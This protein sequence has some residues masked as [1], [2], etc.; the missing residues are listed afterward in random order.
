[1][2]LIAVLCWVALGIAGPA[3]ALPT[4]DSTG[5]VI[6]SPDP[7]PG[8]YIVTL[9]SR[10]PEVVA[11]TVAG[12]TDRHGGQ[13]LDVYTQA[14]QGYAVATTV[15]QAEELA[16]DP[17][18]ASVEQ[19]GYVS[20]SDI[21]S[22]QSPTPSWGLDRVDQRA[23][24]GDNSYSWNA[25]GAGVTAY[26]IDSGINTSLADFGGRASV[27]FDGVT[28]STGGQDCAGHG[29]HVAGT[30]GGTT[31]G[32]A[33]K[34]SL[35]SVRVL[36][37]TG[38]GSFDQVI[39]GVN[40]VTA[41]AVKPA[42]ANM[43][44]GGAQ[45]TALDTAV[46]NSIASGI[47]Y[48]IA[49]GNQ[50]TDACTSSPADVPAALT[51]GATD[52]T[53]TRASFSDYGPCVDLFAPGVNITSDWFTSPFTQTV[54][55]TSMASPHVAGIAARYLAS[56]PSA[57]V[58]DVT[59]AVLS[60]ATTGT[61]GAAGS[62]SPNLLAY[63]GFT[64]SDA[65]SALAPCA[66]SAAAVGGNHVVHL[67]WAL[68][69]AGAAATSVNIYRGT[70]PGAEGNTPF[71]A[72]LAPSTTSF[73]DT[74]AQ[75]GTTYYYQVAAVNGSGEA[76]SNEVAAL[77]AGPPGA[78]TLSVP[79]A[80]N[81]TV[82]LS[83]TAPASNGGSPITQYKI[84]RGTSPGGEGTSSIA[85]VGSA[86]TSYDDGTVTNG[87]TYYYQVAA[88]NSAGETRS[89]ERSASPIGPPAAP[90]VTPSPH[91]TSI[92]LSWPVPASGG[93][94][95]TSYRVYRGTSPGAEA[96]TPISPGNYTQTTFSDSAV[97]QGV[98]YYYQVTAVDSANRE[99]ARS[100]EIVSVAGATIDVF[101]Q[102]GVAGEI[103]TQRVTG[104]SAAPPTSL[105]AVG[106][107]APTATAD[108]SGTAVFARGSD[109]ALWWRRIL[110]SGTTPWASLGGGI[111]GDPVPV[112]T[113]SGLD[114]FV[115]GVDNSVYW[116]HITGTVA[117]PTPVGYSALGGVTTSPPAVG[118]VGTKKYVFVRGGDG[119]VYEQ[120]VDSNP[121]SWRYLGGYISSNPTVAPDAIGSGGV[122]VFA[123]GGD[124][125]MYRQHVAP[126]GTPAG[127]S[128]LGGVITSNPG[129]T[130]DG[131]NTYVFVRG[132]DGGVY[133][134]KIPPSAPPSG[135]IGLA[136]YTNSDPHPLYDGTRTRVV[137]RGGDNR[138][139]WQAPGFV[140]WTALTAVGLSE[141]AVS[142]VP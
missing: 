137:V 114:V 60:N 82:H 133:Y 141:P 108:S 104:S 135:W 81:G 99:S 97:I 66:P 110:P 90:V 3:L 68:N 24:V 88:V 56:C 21:T 140:G 23:T 122:T 84:F 75:N 14:L 9:R 62:G 131:T 132:N 125:G 86:T 117:S 134:Q 124:L 77:A 45:S 40:W 13:V 64:A 34:V 52:I 55:G 67:S 107:G 130:F 19:N 39:A 57:T 25:D 47:T 72:N 98:T 29:T 8:E 38:K 26:V 115:R 96:A 51:V 92:G 12:L 109:G 70:A 116:E 49:A 30:I 102:T 58:G 20:A 74:T 11:P 5:T 41:N 4:A 69:G 127:W 61:V 120:T 136:G 28:P 83:W 139:Y 6:P 111:I 54:S 15:H 138:L 32:V 18:V 35:V 31:Y 89:I 79:V 103:N 36:D 27:G 17:A 63:S 106:V 113:S 85:S 95:V 78:P 71:V 7:V 42:V 59:N 93:S 128:A 126:D 37:C 53:D 105:G 10:S 76:R 1:V 100:S 94:P 46:A 112:T 118:A 73:D 80:G 2:V 22:P 33:K 65:G 48:A 101:N 44:L 123:R 50:G 129:S 16:A 91:L 87:T 121:T 43:S 119:A 142:N